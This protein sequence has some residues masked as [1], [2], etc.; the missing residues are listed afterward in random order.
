MG[1]YSSYSVFTLEPRFVILARTGFA[2]NIFA[3]SHSLIRLLI[4]VIKSYQISPDIYPDME[5]FMG[6]AYQLNYAFDEA[7]T[8]YNT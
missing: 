2:Y 5:Y 7:K 1:E 3:L 6:R 4:L 8:H